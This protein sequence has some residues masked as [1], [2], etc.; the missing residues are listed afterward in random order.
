MPISGL[1]FL[2]LHVKSFLLR[3]FN[4]F[5]PASTL[6]LRIQIF[7]SCCYLP[8]LHFLHIDNKVKAYLCAALP[9]NFFAPYVPVLPYQTFS[10]DTALIYF[11]QRRCWS[12]DCIFFFYVKILS[13]EIF[14]RISTCKHFIASDPDF[15]L[16]LHHRIV[17]LLRRK[18]LEKQNTENYRTKKPHTLQ[19]R[20]LT[21]LQ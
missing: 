19:P 1:H 5:L 16:L 6:L 10:D 7:S 4:V 15:L 21:T 20:L 13:A 17:Y 2:F 11:G 8:L 18:F 9:T 3:Y 12:Q 14:Y